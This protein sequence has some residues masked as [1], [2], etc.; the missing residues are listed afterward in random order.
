MKRCICA[1][2]N[3]ENKEAALNDICSQLKSNEAD[4]RVIIFTAD[5]NNFEYF[6]CEIKNH[7][8]NSE[9]IGMSTFIVLSSKGYSYNSFA[10][11][12]I[13]ENIKYS[14]G[15]ILEAN[16]HPLKYAQ[17]ITEAL[18]NFC[19]YENTCCFTFTAAVD[20]CEE[21]VTETY[22]SVLEPIDVPICGGSAGSPLDIEDSFVSLNGKTYNKASVFI[23][24]KNLSGRIGI[25]K[26]NL[27]KPTKHIL[28][29]T[30]VDCDERIVY[31]FDGQPA[32]DCLARTMNITI[33]E[34]R[35]QLK[36][37][38]IGRLEDDDIYITA[39]DQI[40]NEHE[41]HYY[42]R[43]YNRTKVALLEAGNIEDES[44]RT[45]A[46]IHMDYPES[47]FALVINCIGRSLYYEEHDKM[48]YFTQKLSEEYGDYIGFSGFGEQMH[49]SHFN[50]TMVIAIFE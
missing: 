7:F 29:V 28:T 20:R 47:S 43:I 36:Y 49:Y 48:D 3:L 5:Y 18:N 45:A 4:P 39:G 32:A 34:L 35:D 11:M 2:S 44:N 33:D 25:Y 16:T 40:G 24:I 19:S 26:E 46:M 23:L 37:R 31:E 30:D 50:M 27:F 6:A 15:I 38:P 14:S 12:G 10:A 22:R 41:I 9:T 42:A 21:I 13:Y 8:P 17:N 1:Y